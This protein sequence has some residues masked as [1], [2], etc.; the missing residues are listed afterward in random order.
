MAGMKVV[1]MTEKFLMTEDAKPLVLA[2][3]SKVRAK[4]L[5][6][7]GLAFA[8]RPA[9]VD[10]DAIKQSLLAE[11]AKPREIA[12]TLAEMKAQKVSRKLVGEGKAGCFTIGAD[13]VLAC[14]NVLFDKPEDMD[15]AAAHL[16]ALSGKTH[17]LIS[18]AVI[19]KDGE[20]IWRQIDKASLTM[21]PLSDATIAHYLDVAG[22]VVLTSVGAYQIEGPGLQ[23]FSHIT[24]LWSTIQGLPMLELLDFLRANNVIPE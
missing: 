4:L 13:Q 18:A 19:A 9:H 2:S 20:V 11:N 24:G 17:E 1:K 10:E 7:A 12:E 3:Q 16:R 22:D 6:G 21:R 5:E 23:L 8:Q 15:H 14:N